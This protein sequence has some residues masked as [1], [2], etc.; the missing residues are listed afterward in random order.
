MPLHL[1][2]QKLDFENLC[3]ATVM[4]G[5]RGRFSLGRGGFRNENY[6]GRGGFGAGRGYVRSEYRSQGEFFPRT[7]APMGRG[8]EGY[9]RRSYQNGSGRGSRGGVNHGPPPA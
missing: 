9:Q 6:R 3:L 7:R 5:G 1:G 2:A 4:S 8:G